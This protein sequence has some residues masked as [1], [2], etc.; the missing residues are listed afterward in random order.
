MSQA[1]EGIVN[2]KDGARGTIRLW[3]LNQDDPRAL[4]QFNDGQ[5]VVVPSDAL[6][7]QR[8][9]SYYLS[10][11]RDELQRQ[12]NVFGGS[13]Q[14]VQTAQRDND[15]TRVIPLI[16][17][18]AVVQ[19]QRVES[20][21][22]RLHKSVRERQEIID[23]LLYREEAQIEHVPV[24]RI[25]D[26][27]EAPR[28]EGD[29]L[30]VPLMEQTLVVEKRLML[31]EELRITKRQ[32]E[33]HEPQRVTLRREEVQVERTPNQS[34]TS[35]IAAAN[36]EQSQ[37][38]AGTNAAYM[39]TMPVNQAASQ[40]QLEAGEERVIPVVVEELN[41]RKERVETGVRLSKVVHEQEEVID[42][43]LYREEVYV[44]RVSVNRVVNEAAATRYEGDTMIVPLYEEVVAVE[45]RLRITE[46]LHI[47]R[48]QVPFREPQRVTLRSEE[49]ELER[50]PIQENQAANRGTNNA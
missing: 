9:G 5:Q 17:E 46:E 21:R 19:K 11:S 49:V 34:P 4:I 38:N 13:S 40:E 15:Q 14:T 12:N 45:Q 23:Q 18:H 29:T 41:V 6:T 2:T 37:T 7:L 43:P 26:Q 32:I 1:R 30:I 35:G 31:K 3:P 28:N 20:G 24:N 25:V 47:T 22:V 16:V 44:E 8:D 50:I 42:Q 48:R 36:R 39:P 10:F 27:A 33:Y